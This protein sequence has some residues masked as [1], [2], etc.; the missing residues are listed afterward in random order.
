[1]KKIF[2]LA[3]FLSLTYQGFV[4]N[5]GIGTTS[6]LARL[7]VADSS[8]V[9][10]APGTANFI[11]PGNPAISGTG[12]RMMWYPD[13][14]AFRTGYVDGS[15]WD[16]INTGYY[17]FASGFNS[18]ASGGFSTALGSSVA[19]GPYSLSGGYSTSASGFGSIAFGFNTTAKAY[20][21][22]SLGALNDATDNP[23]PQNATYLDRIFQVGNGDINSQTRSNALTV[24]RSGYVGIGTVSPQ[25]VLHVQSNNINPVIFDGGS[26]MWIT[27]A[28]DG[29]NRGYIGSYAGNPEDVELGAYGGTLGSV[30]LTTSN[31]PRLTVINNGNV[32]IGTTGPSEKL[33]VSGNV[34]ATSYKYSTP[35]TNYCSIPPSAFDKEFNA[36]TIYRDYGAVSFASPTNSTGSYLIAP[37]NLPH[38][39]TITG[40]TV[41]YEDNSAAKN[42]VITLMQHTH[43]QPGATTIATFTS[44]GTP[45]NT[46]SSVVVA[47]WVVNNQTANYCIEANSTPM[48]WPG[49]SILI[50]GVVIT[51]TLSEAP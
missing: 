30:H 35:R 45:G 5:V 3:I 19:S 36:D 39:A 49:F 12:R 40:F 38:G 15:Q 4:Q 42:L 20:G 34:K 22:I 37:V 25:T 1:M 24:L 51:Y 11:S 9:F 16:K 50:R 17:S 6:P 26:P 48:P 31:T 28:E 43:S 8:V 32:G 10:G 33:E 2:P 41:Y 14:G 18:M 7:H 44:S 23:D 27:L 13:K 21:S 29:I 47:G 46:S